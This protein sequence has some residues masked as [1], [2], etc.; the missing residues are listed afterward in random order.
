M[1]LAVS[2]S[3][4][5]FLVSITGLP[6][7]QF[8]EAANAHTDNRCTG[9]AGSISQ[10]FRAKVDGA[11]QN[12]QV[13]TDAIVAETFYGLNANIEPRTANREPNLNTNGEPSTRKRER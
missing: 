7:S 12:L 4:D 8:G 9:D 1:R 13:E 2:Q 5:R 6:G 10:E 3:I 11:V